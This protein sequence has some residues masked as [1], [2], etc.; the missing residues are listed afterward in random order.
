[1]KKAILSLVILTS[2]FV[3]GILGYNK[4]FGYKVDFKLP[5]KITE[6]LQII[7]KS[8]NIE[9]YVKVFDLGVEKC[10]IIATL[11]GKTSLESF[12]VKVFFKSSPMPTSEIHK[13]EEGQRL[14]CL[15]K[16]LKVVLNIFES[17]KTKQEFIKFSKI[18]FKDFKGQEQIQKNF[19]NK[20]VKL[21]NEKGELIILIN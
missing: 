21:Q 12:K 4:L 15:E 3:M 18:L 13:K 14:E 10:S 8:S 9:G 20:T 6:N 11:T 19:F 16:T 7:S 5:D 2:L 17:K 1:M